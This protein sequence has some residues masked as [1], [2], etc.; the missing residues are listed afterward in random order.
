MA[1]G[2]EG[3]LGVQTLQDVRFGGLEESRIVVV[4][5]VLALES[6]AERANGDKIEL[7]VEGGGAAIGVDHVVD[8]LRRQFGFLGERIVDPALLL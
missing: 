2:A 6:E 3:E 4:V 8:E 7:P 1:I 5:A